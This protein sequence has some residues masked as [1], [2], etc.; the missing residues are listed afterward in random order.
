MSTEDLTVEQ[1]NAGMNELISMLDAYLDFNFN[2]SST[3]SVTGDAPDTTDRS[4]EA[5]L[6]AQ[7]EEMTNTQKVSE[8]YN[9][10]NALGDRP[11]DAIDEEG[12]NTSANYHA[13]KAAKEAQAEWDKAISDLEVEYQQYLR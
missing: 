7:L 6:A 4:D 9:E 5:A 8:Y 1:Q 10:L 11:P 13:D 2:L 12:F 3:D